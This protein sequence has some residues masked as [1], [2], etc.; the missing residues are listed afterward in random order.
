[1]PKSKHRK[2][3]KSK[4]SKRNEIK[5][6]KDKALEKRSRE[7]IKK[8]IEQEKESGKFDNVESYDSNNSENEN[9]ESEKS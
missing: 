3:H 7:F 4:V 9:V 5:K 2:N 6:Q 8:V 1:M